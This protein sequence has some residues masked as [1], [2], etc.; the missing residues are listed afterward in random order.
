MF[1]KDEQ[2]VHGGTEIFFGG[3]ERETR[4][5][6]RNDD[7]HSIKTSIHVLVSKLLFSLYPSVYV[8]PLNFSSFF[9]VGKAA[10]IHAQHC[11]YFYAR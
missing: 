9:F 11:L 5:G 7:D 6:I 4:E 10:C 3:K 2:I 8:L 1:V